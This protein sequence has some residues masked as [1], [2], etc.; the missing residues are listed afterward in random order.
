[1]TKT[2]N[3]LRSDLDWLA[4]QV[5]DTAADLNT[6]DLTAEERQRRHARWGHHY[7]W[8]AKLDALAADLAAAHEREQTPEDEVAEV[9]DQIAHVAAL[10]A[11]P[12]EADA[13]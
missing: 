6:A 5:Q 8:R 10:V 9:E 2:V 7:Q 13:A 1:M 3:H 11:D 4:A 12:A